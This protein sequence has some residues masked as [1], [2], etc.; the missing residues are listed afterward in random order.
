VVLQLVDRHGV[1]L[2][3]L[4]TTT[5]IG[6]PDAVVGSWPSTAGA[7]ILGDASGSSDETVTVYWWFN[8]GRA[9]R[10]RIGYLVQGAGATL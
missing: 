6:R 3:D 10:Y 5:R 7:R 4:T 8:F 1:P 2:G 9:C